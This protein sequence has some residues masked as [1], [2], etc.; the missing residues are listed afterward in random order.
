MAI[1]KRC[2]GLQYANDS[3]FTSAGTPS[4][5]IR[6]HEIEWSPDVTMLPVEH[7]KSL[8]NAGPDVSVIGGLGGELKFKQYL[9]PRSDSDCVFAELAK[10]TAVHQHD[11]DATADSVDAGSAAGTLVM[12]DAGY[13]PAD[14]DGIII[15]SS[16]VSQIRW[17][18]K[19]ATVTGTI[20]PNWATT[21]SHED[22][23][24]ASTSFVPMNA[25]SYSANILG[26]PS[27]YLSFDILDE[28]DQ[29]T[30]LSGCA[31][32]WKL[33]TATANSLPT[34]E[35]TYKVDR[36]S[37]SGT[38]A[39][40]AWT[41][42]EATPRPLLG[43]SFYVNDTATAIRSIAFDP[44]M[45]IVPIDATSGTHGRAGWYYV[46]SNPKIEIE[47]LFSGTIFDYWAS[48]T[49]SQL[50]INSIS[51][52]GVG[53]GLYIP[54]AQLIKGTQGD[55]NGLVS[56]KPEIQICDA[57]FNDEVSPVKIPDWCLTMNA[58]V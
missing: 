12:H 58:G 42:S 14:G 5:N 34:I 30:T 47:L 18:Y 36:W 53:W 41:C 50:A 26:E 35:W 33:A 15:K 23:T 57:G 43:D 55:I 56:L 49:T 1:V 25:G 28:D 17:L 9:A 31:G 24:L 32:T 37:R 7:Q 16:A 11:L 13:F 4:T 54:K 19:T 48:G 21:P 44:G 39:A 8:S 20:E 10:L 29:V 51:A 6:A 45:E 22:D 52:A 40:T 2:K 38:G 27:A 3:S 46:A